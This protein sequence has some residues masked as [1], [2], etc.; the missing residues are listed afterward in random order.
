M[1]SN[2]VIG[3]VYQCPAIKLTGNAKTNDLFLFFHWWITFKRRHEFSRT[4]LAA[5]NRLKFTI[6]SWRFQREIPM[7]IQLSPRQLR[8]QLLLWKHKLI[9]FR[10]LP[11]CLLTYSF[12]RHN[13]T[14]LDSTGNN[15][16]VRLYYH[17]HI[18]SSL[19]H[20]SD[21]LYDLTISVCHS[22]RF[23]VIK[24]CNSVSS[25]SAHSCAGKNC[26]K[27]IDSDSVEM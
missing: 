4:K 18:C 7:S 5:P 9:I 24:L 16:S 19:R 11:S 23:T 6:T 21:V 27:H 1:R 20:E 8:F 2:I 14:C 25:L 15:L 22:N 13:Y 12:I 3:V 10:S 17:L 26:T